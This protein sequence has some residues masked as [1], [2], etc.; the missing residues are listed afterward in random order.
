MRT[1]IQFD[2]ELLKEA[3]AVAAASGRTLAELV[4]ESV[5]ENL[6]RRKAA[7]GG[8]RISLPTFKGGDVLPGVD[9]S[10]SAALL[11]IMEGRSASS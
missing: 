7:V 9:I 2:D 5:R 11:D 6:A 8:K 4:E 10:N 1:T 3:K